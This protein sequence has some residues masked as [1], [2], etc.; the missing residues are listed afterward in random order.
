MFDWIEIFLLL[1]AASLLIGGMTPQ[2]RRYRSLFWVGG[3]LMLITALYPRHSNAL[4]QYLF[5]RSSGAPRLPLELFGMPWW[6]LGAW[7]QEPA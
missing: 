3:A 2:F 6:L 4:G 5:G 7:L 1:A